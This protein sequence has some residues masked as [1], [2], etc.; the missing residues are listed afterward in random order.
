MKPLTQLFL[1][2]SLIYSLAGCAYQKKAQI[3]ETIVEVEEDTSVKD[4]NKDKNVKKDISYL[5]KNK[6]SYVKIES[7]KNGFVIAAKITHDYFGDIVSYL[8]FFSYVRIH[9]ENFCELWESTGYYH[10]EKC[11]GKVDWYWKNTM[12]TGK[13]RD[14][15]FEEI[16]KEYKEKSSPFSPEKSIEEWKILNGEADMSSKIKPS[17]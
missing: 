5:L 12:Q 8:P 17:D 13:L 15:E 10:D 6:N 14:N 9:G 2:A 11:D 4:T 3:P 1:A 16:D 7:G